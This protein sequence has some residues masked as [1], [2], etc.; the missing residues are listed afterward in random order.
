M[1]TLVRLTLQYLET[2]VAELSQ[3][4]CTSCHP[5]KALADDVVCVSYIFIEGWCSVYYTYSLKGD[6]VCISY[7]FIEGWHG[8]YIVH[9]HWKIMCCVCRTYSLKDVVS[10]KT[11]WCLYYSYSLKGDVVFTL[12][13]F[14]VP[15]CLSD[16][17]T[18]HWTSGITSSSKTL[19]YR[20]THACL[21]PYWTDWNLSLSGGI[22]S[23]CEPLAKILCP[24]IW[25]TISTITQPSGLT[26]G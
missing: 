4:R 26:T 24:T 9:I 12:Y 10:L 1:C 18:W 19:L 22:L 11:I 23:I 3:A 16:Q 17:K 21:S 13:I 15:C 25:L 8:V 7:I 20:Q 2:V 14:Y 5:A 6:V